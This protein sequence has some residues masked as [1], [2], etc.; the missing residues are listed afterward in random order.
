MDRV[1]CEAFGNF[2]SLLQIQSLLELKVNKHIIEVMIALILLKTNKKLP[3][4]KRS[5]MVFLLK[6]F[7]K[8]EDESD[9]YLQEMWTMREGKINL[10][11]EWKIH[12]EFL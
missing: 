5:L 2:C 7:M 10:D 8:E 9:H 3:T 11:K 6:F 12:V 4:R 1:V